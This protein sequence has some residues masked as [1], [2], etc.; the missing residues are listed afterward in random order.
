MKNSVLLFVI[1]L[2]LILFCSRVAYSQSTKK[3][4]VKKPVNETELNKK[5]DNCPMMLL[6]GTEST[7]TIS[8]KSKSDSTQLSFDVSEQ[9]IRNKTTSI[10][11]GMTKAQVSLNAKKMGVELLKKTS[12]YW[13]FSNTGLMLIFQNDKLVSIPGMCYNFE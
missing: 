3:N 8:S 6:N 13:F 12:K 9:E 5:Y 1:S 2:L 11:L 10:R 4:E 7:L